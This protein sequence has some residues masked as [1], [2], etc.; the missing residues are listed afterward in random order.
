MSRHLYEVRRAKQEGEDTHLMGAI[1]GPGKPKEEKSGVDV[2]KDVDDS[3]SV[4]Q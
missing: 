4:P 3:K 2:D 1:K